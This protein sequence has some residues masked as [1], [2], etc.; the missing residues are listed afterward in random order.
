MNSLKGSDGCYVPGL[1][2][3]RGNS[4]FYGLLLHALITASALVFLG[5]QIGKQEHGRLAT[6]TPSPNPAADGKFDSKKLN[7]SLDGDYIYGSKA[8]RVSL[9]S[10]VDFE[11]SFC[12]RFYPVEKDLV[13]KS[14]GRINLV[15]R[16]YPLDFHPHADA[17]ANAALCVGHQKGEAAYWTFIDK[18]L[19]GGSVGDDLDAYISHIVASQQVDAQVLSDCIRKQQ[20]EDRIR[21]YAAEARAIGVRG[22]PATVLYDW[23]NKRAKLI[24]GSR[25]SAEFQAALVGL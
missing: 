17:L 19:T 6:S 2:G 25:D 23:V 22:T 1:R 20:F 21:T 24:S 14:A 11:C 5:L 8:A 13:D 9:I 7:T 4:T 10:F 18:V 15:L 16:M 3:Q 12:A